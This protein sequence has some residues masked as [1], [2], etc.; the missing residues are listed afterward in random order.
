MLTLK[1][2]HKTFTIS[3][4]NLQKAE[5]FNSLLTRW[6]HEEVITIDEDTTK[7]ISKID[8]EATKKII[9][10]DEDPHLFRH[11][12]NCLRH[13]TYEIPEKYT[14]NVYKLLDFYGVKYN[15]INNIEL[16]TTKCHYLENSKSKNTVSFTGQLLSISFHSFQVTFSSYKTKIYIWFNNKLLFDCN[17]NRSTLNKDFGLNLESISS[18]RELYGTFY[19][20]IAYDTENINGCNILYNEK[21]GK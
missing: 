8:E 5:Y 18:I 2:G 9:M 1:A 3:K 11:F 6:N 16:R 17:L 20:E 21:I 19:I 14:T 15:K 10:I 12:L 4:D 13:P 7:K